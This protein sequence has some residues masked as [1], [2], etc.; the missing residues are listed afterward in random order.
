MKI[1]AKDFYAL[2][3]RSIRGKDDSPMLC[4]VFSSRREAKEV[5]EGIKECPGKHSIKKCSVSVTI[6]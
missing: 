6:T 5:A 3:C 4:G 1:T 2:T